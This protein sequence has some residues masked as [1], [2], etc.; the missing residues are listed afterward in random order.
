MLLVRR[1]RL[2]AG[3]LCSRAAMWVT[4]RAILAERA[5]ELVWKLYTP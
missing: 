4:L 1:S 3:W 5:G 2:M